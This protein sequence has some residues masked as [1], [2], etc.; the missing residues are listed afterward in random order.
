MP[1][2]PRISLGVKPVEIANPLSQYSQLAQ[3]QNYQQANQLNALKMQ[4]AQRALNTQ[5]ALNQAYQS[6]YDPTTQSVDQNRLLGTL[7]QQ[8]YGAQIPGVQKGLLEAQEAKT[9]LRKANMDVIKAKME[10][11]KPLYQQALN[12]ANPGAAM[13][14]IHS[15]V[16]GDPVLGPWLE[17]MGV[18]ADRGEQDIMAAITQGP[19]AVRSKLM[20]SI[21]SVEQL[22]PQLVSIDTGGGTQLGTRSQLTGAYTAGTAVPKT[23]LP[24]DVMADKVKL[25]QAGASNVTVSTDKAYG[26]EVAK[27]G[28]EEDLAL[29]NTAQTAPRD[30]GKIDETLD[31]LR[32]QDI[33]TGIGAELFNALDKARGQFL[34]DK[35]AGKRV[36]ST[37]YL[38]SLLGSD[39]FPLIQSLGIGARGMDTPAER[40][41]LRKVMTGTIS[42]N[43]E[44]LIKMAERRRKAIENEVGRFND[45]VDKGA[46]DD[47]FKARK[48]PK[49][50]VNL[51]E[52][53]KATST[54]TDA[55][56]GT[57]GMPKNVSEED[58]LNWPFY[59]D[60]TR[61]MFI[62]SYKEQ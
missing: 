35:E 10:Q 56:A 1:I 12:S 36:T 34:A 45:L 30:V 9:K 22:L 33:N 26:G 48:R 7:A 6:A 49:G 3:I 15:G 8:G 60:K 38:D 13:L 17:S 24:A 5:N 43:K 23:P 61:Q 51:P 20:Q 21:A 14:E 54:P 50:K 37:E 62:D 58:K 57:L 44:T 46:L 53:P 4:E 2:D 27:G 19:E 18:T 31:V 25:A 42:L 29:F 32:N 28:A 16:H 11:I 52:A 39:V 59:D 41:F 40:E 47:F 55:Q